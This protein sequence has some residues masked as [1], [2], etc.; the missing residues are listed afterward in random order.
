IGL[1]LFIST[2]S[3]CQENFS[4]YSKFDFVPGEKTIF[5]DDFSQ[6]NVGDFP[7]KWN[8]NGK[9]EVVTSN[10]YPGKW[11]KMRNSTTYLP[12]ISSAKLP[13]N[14]TIEYDLVFKG[15]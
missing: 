5:F 1:I 8:T 12:S 6:D 13:E 14:Y 4:S 10:L 2:R 15:E 7:G 9:G 11:L 3:Y